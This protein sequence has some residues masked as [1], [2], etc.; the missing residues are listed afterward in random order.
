MADIIPTIATYHIYIQVPKVK[1]TIHSI[2]K[3]NI[4]EF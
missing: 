4:F 2:T 3:Y 1:N